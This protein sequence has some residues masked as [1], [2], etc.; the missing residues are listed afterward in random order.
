MIISWRLCALAVN[1]EDMKTP[2][3]IDPKLYE[4]SLDLLNDLHFVES[5][6]KLVD[7]S[8]FN[9]DK[10]LSE[11]AVIENLAKVA[12]QWDI[13]LLFAM[14]NNPL[15]FIKRFIV[16]YSCPRKA[17]LFASIMRR[18]AAKDQRGT[19]AVDFEGIQISEN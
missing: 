15:K 9:D 14:H 2:F 19:L 17:T 10:W 16:S 4:K 6:G 8:F 7:F 12:G 18:Q 3:F 1:I 5:K 11:T 13:E